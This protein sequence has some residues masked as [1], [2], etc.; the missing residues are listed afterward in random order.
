MM[1]G[2]VSRDLHAPKC[3]A[4]SSDRFI[5]CLD[6][7]CEHE[8]FQPIKTADVRR[9]PSLPLPPLRLRPGSGKMTQEQSL[10][11][12]IS[13]SSSPDHFSKDL[14]QATS[15]EVMSVNCIFQKRLLD[16][17][18]VWRMCFWKGV[19]TGHDNLFRSAPL[20]KYNTEQRD[21]ETS[22]S[23]KWKGEVSE[24]GILN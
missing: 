24:A 1:S 14:L 12:V 4:S 21:K 10:D 23:G 6:I 9:P 8:A 13:G 2:W 5:G 11:E 19:N 3:R 16:R 17:V 18:S 7:L 22:I 15:K 20:L